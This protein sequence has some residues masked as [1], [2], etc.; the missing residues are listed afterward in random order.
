MRCRAYNHLKPYSKAY[1]RPLAST[2][3]Y[4]NVHQSISE[5]IIKRFDTRQRQEK[6]LKFKVFDVQ[7]PGQAGYDIGD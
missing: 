4:A 6:G 1:H 7:I 3:N 5:A 2:N